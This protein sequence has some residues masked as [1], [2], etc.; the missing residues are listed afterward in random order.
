MSYFG[1]NQAQQ[2]REL[3]TAAEN[4]IGSARSD[5]DFFDGAFTAPFKGIY[6]GVTQAD[7]V[8]WSGVDAVVSP[9][10]RAV[11]DAFGVNDTSES[12]IKNQRKLAEQQVRALTPD[13]GTTG[14]AGQVLFSLAEVGGQAAAGTLLGGLPGAAATVG[15]LQGFSDYEK[16]RA[17]GV[18]YGTAVEKALVTGG[19]AAL[20]AVLPM[21]LGLRAGGAVAEGVGAALTTGGTAAGAVAGAVARAAPDLL[22]SAGTNVAMGMAQRGL[23]AEILR[24]GGYE[25]MARQYDVFDNQALAVDA[26]LGIAFGGLGRFINSRGESVAVRSAEPA[27][28]DA[29]LTSSSHLNYEVTASPGVPVSVLSRNA[30]SRAMDKAMTDALAGHPVDVGSLMDGAE[31]IQRRPRVDL[32]SQE[33]RKAMGLPDVVIRDADAARFDDV[34]GANY[35]AT[36]KPRTREQIQQDEIAGA[37]RAIRGDDSRAA[38]ADT[39][40]AQR[41]ISDNPDLQVHV[42]NP[43]D[44]TTVVRAADLMAEADRDVVNAQHDANLFD[45]AVSCFLRR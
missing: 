31:F 16:S 27:E 14:T 18:D 3:A 22:Y 40:E 32:A 12:F 9:I 25:D 1:F 39:L 44:S 8:A 33:V 17:D 28:I 4:P 20:G 42:V 5:A 23:S 15:G 41:A 21:S 6:A 29:A 26:V 11:N 2:N 38:E 43:D 7:Q 36:P 13:A 35:L 45:V 34:A 10:S 24:R 37:E 19:T 30:H